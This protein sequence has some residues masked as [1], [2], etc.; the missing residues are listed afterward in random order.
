[1]ENRREK[2]SKLV[3]QA[4]SANI[5]IIEVAQRKTENRPEKVK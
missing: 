2:I 4:R 1:M 5:Q 3:E